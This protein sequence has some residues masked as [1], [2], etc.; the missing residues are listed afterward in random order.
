M[1]IGNI[2]TS[3]LKGQI[4]IPASIR[5]QL[6]ITD[7]VPLQ[8]MVKGSV[9]YIM[10]IRDVVT[11]ADQESSYFDILIKTKGTWRNEKSISA[12]RKQLELEA[13]AKRKEAW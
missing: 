9:L 2:I 7:Q 5:T 8:L 11:V 1:K 4:V 12:Q 6:G 3:N 10:P 13:S